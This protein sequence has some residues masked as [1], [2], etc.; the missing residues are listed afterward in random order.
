[1]FNHFIASMTYFGLLVDNWLNIILVILQQA[2]VGN[3]PECQSMNG[4]LISDIMSSTSIFPTNDPL[5]VIGLTG[6]IYAITNGKTIVYKGHSDVATKFGLW[7]YTVNSLYGMAAVTYSNVND[8]V[9][10]TVS[11]GNTFQAMQTT[12]LLGCNC[13]D[14]DNNQG[15]S[16]VCAIAPINGWSNDNKTKYRLQVIVP[17]SH[18]LQCNWID[19]H[20][21]SNRFSFQR[22]SAVDVNYGQGITSMPD[23]DCIN[24]KNCREVDASIWLVPRCGQ[25]MGKVIAACVPGSSCFPYCMGVRL[26]GS[27]NN[28]IIMSSAL[29]WKSGRTLINRDCSIYDSTPE[30]TLERNGLGS[31]NVQ[32]SDTV[33]GSTI[34]KSLFS[35]RS[36]NVNTL[37]PE[38]YPVQ[39]VVSTVKNQDFSSSRYNT[40]SKNQPFVIAGDSIFTAK[41]LG[42]GISSVVIDRLES[43]Q[44]NEFTLHTLNQ[45][46]PAEAPPNV[47]RDETKFLN[48]DRILLPYSTR[49]GHPVAT[50]SRN[51]VFYA[52]NPDY[53]VFSA[54]LDYCNRDPG[55]M[56]KFGLIITSSYGPLRIYRVKAYAK[57]SAYSCGA[58]LVKSIDF[59]GFKT[60]YNSKC[61][62]SLNV[63]ITQ[64]EYLNED[65]IAVVVSSSP[66]QSFETNTNSFSVQTS[67]V[68]WLN[69][70]TMQIS[71]NIWQTTVAKSNLGT[72]CPGLQ[73]FPRL[74]SMVAELVNANVYLFQYIMGIPLYLPGVINIWLDGGKCTQ[75]SYGHSILD[76]CG[77][78]IF[79]L[80]NMFDSYTDAASI[81]WHSLNS[82]SYVIQFGGSNPRNNPISDILDGMAQYGEGTIDFLAIQSSVITLSKIPM[83]EQ[84]PALVGSIQ[85]GSIFTSFN[86]AQSNTL[87]WARF[88]YNVFKEVFLVIFKSSLKN[89]QMTSSEIWQ[90]L[91]DTLYNLKGYYKSTVVETNQLACSGIKLMFGVDN[92]W[93]TLAYYMCI[94]NTGLFDSILDT[95]LD[96]TVYVPMSV[97]VCKEGTGRNLIQYAANTCSKKLP[98]NVRPELFIISAYVQEQ[99]SNAIGSTLC[100]TIINHTRNKIVHSMDP[101]FSNMNLALIALSEA[102]D[103]LLIVLD[104]Q[105]GKCLDFQ[106]NPHVIAIVPQPIDYFQACGK[107]SSCKMKCNAEWQLFEEYK[108]APVQM[109]TISI[110]Y[111]SMFFPGQYDSNNNMQYAMAVMEITDDN[112]GYCTVKNGPQD[113]ILVIS[114]NYNSIVTSNVWCIPQSP[115]STVYKSEVVSNFPT[116]TLPG[117]IM[118]TFFISPTLLCFLLRIN[119]INQVFLLDQ[120]YGLRQAPDVPLG[121]GD[122]LVNILNI[123]PIMET[124][125]IDV[126]IRKY[127]NTLKT[128]TPIS[129]MYSYYLNSRT[130]MW[131]KVTKFDISSFATHYKIIQ[132]SLQNYEYLLLPTQSFLYAYNL[133]ITKLGNGDVQSDVTMLTAFDPTNTIS[134]IYDTII[135]SHIISN[136]YVFAITP[137]GWNWLQQV[138]FQVVNNMKQISTIKQSSSVAMSIVPQGNCDEYSCEGCKT[139]LVQRLC[140]AYN[141]CA[142]VRC[143][144]TLVNEMRPLCAIG[145]T[146]AYKGTE[147]LQSVYAAWVVIAEMLCTTLKVSLVSTTSLNIEWPDDVFM[148]YICNSKDLFV[149]FWAIFTSTLNVLMH[150]ANTNP[151]QAFKGSSKIDKNVDAALTIKSTALNAFLAQ[152]TLFPIY[153]LIAIKQIVSCQVNGVLAISDYTG[154]SIRIISP[155]LVNATD[156]VAGSCLTLSNQIASQYMSS[157]DNS[158]SVTTTT[159]GNIVDF[160]G[161]AVNFAVLQSID[162]IIHA[163]DAGITY[164]LGNIHTMAVLIMASYPDLC[165]PPDFFL[166]E[167]IQC[168]CDD[169]RLSIPKIRSEAAFNE[170]PLWCTG[171]LGMIDSSNSPVIVFNP[172]T[173]AELQAKATG[174]QSFVACLSQNYNCEGPYDSF[175]EAQGVTL[176]NVLVKCRENY[177]KKQWDPK[178]FAFFDIRET[179]FSMEKNYHF[180]DTVVQECLVDYHSKGEGPQA[181]QEQYINK[182]GLRSSEVYWAYERATQPGPEFTDSCLVFTGPGLVHNISTFAACVDGNTMPT[183]G[184]TLN[185]QIWSVLSTNDIPVAETHIVLYKGDQASGI[186]QKYYKEAY[187]KVINAVMEALYVW[188]NTSNTEV[189]VDF[190]ST[191]GDA[192]HQILDCIYMGPYSRINYWPIPIFKDNEENLKGPAWYRDDNEGKS[193]VIDIETCDGGETMPFSCGSPARRS[194]IRYFVKRMLSGQARGNSNT[195]LIQ[196]GV[197]AQLRDI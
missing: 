34:S 194:V 39:N 177:E 121:D 148:G 82:I 6:W 112:H 135:S 85:S 178:A 119:S 154:Y 118:Q 144:G 60:N 47:P 138:R 116:V 32:T 176:T 74:G 8:I 57:C 155:D 58:G 108:T 91:W 7:P 26:S 41:D 101:W 169:Y 195:T 89:T 29:Q 167:T 14:L 120:T 46:F 132:G 90:T 168:A 166:T 187:D 102:I 104:N 84:I 157:E 79:S 62:G 147:S 151:A 153:Q 129:Y 115:S 181:C 113:Y 24:R 188:G 182:L 107:T 136:T 1:M 179:G 44:K 186:I 68:Y 27:T 12:A 105:A 109:P 180:P 21:K 22:Y 165:N 139:I 33:L 185:A 37:T 11:D 111:E 99:G 38:C 52:T 159:Y 141:K 35:Y 31:T 56:A 152:L 81:F 70:S 42:G 163:V 72:L 45:D 78:D 5:V 63:S 193:R 48:Q 18:L 55:A 143:I 76:N 184:C 95:I 173:Y 160:V 117:D 59:D 122:I 40:Y 87:M 77:S 2:L 142:L 189:D 80:E 170:Y 94:A 49:I 100:N 23:T 137:S 125:F 9:V 13:T 134:A 98:L 174:L 69:P 172:Y 158:T 66:I 126:I 133:V 28:N 150:V 93:A 67:T 51:Y 127:T 15:I 183:S 96:I 43:D 191:E 123:W 175:F 86:N 114:E 17:D 75:Q 25:D 65:N 92:P 156:V 145:Q 19:L 50:S 4:A 190:F 64:M 130:T 131:I 110:N 3:A 171:T 128:Y 61:D 73:R 149:E 36:T 71:N 192:I 146:L 54:Y 20:V 10:S 106:G 161:S 103:Y 196:R 140:Q 164:I 83:K 124:V 16:I 30:T 97:C 162:P 197:V 88:T 53:G